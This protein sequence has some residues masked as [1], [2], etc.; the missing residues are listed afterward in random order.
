[1]L[2]K[3]ILMPLMALVL[4]SGTAGA[5]TVD[6]SMLS[7]MTPE[8]RQ[9]VLTGLKGG[10]DLKEDETS[11]GGEAV[12]AEARDRE[13]MISDEKC[14]D[15]EG[16]LLSENEVLENMGLPPRDL[17]ESPALEPDARASERQYEKAQLS[18][19]ERAQLA[20]CASV[21]REARQN[22][23]DEKNA[24]SKLLPVP[25]PFGYDLFEKSS[26]S[27]APVTDIP[28]PAD[29]V[30]G[31]GDSIRVQLTGKENDKFTLMVG[32]DGAINFPKLGPIEVA[33]LGFEDM[34]ALIEEQVATDLIGVGVSVSMGRLRSIRIFVLGDARHPGSYTVSSLSTLTHALYVSG[35]ARTTGSLRRIE[36]RRN[37]RLVRTLDL[38]DLLL[39]G[40]SSSDVRL[41]P[42]DVV[43]IPP[44]G[45]RVTVD[46]AVKRPAVYELLKPISVKQGLELAGG[47]LSSASLS[48]AQLER[49][50]PEQGRVLTA[51]NLDKD[52]ETK[53]RDGDFLRVRQVASVADNS[54]QVVG[55]IKYPGTYP[56]TKGITLGGVL[57]SAELKPSDR[58]EEAYLLMGAIERTD[59]VSGL[60]SFIAFDL[61]ALL[62]ND[63]GTIDLHPRD[64][65]L[66]FSRSDIAF[67]GDRL[68]RD[69]LLGIY[70]PRTCVGLKELR[71]ISNTQRAVRYL[72]A[73]NSDT[74]NAQKS[75]RRE[76]KCPAIF[77]EFPRALGFLLDR[78]VGLYGEVHRPG[79]YPVPEF[80]SVSSVLRGAGGLTREADSQQVEYAPL[81]S[82]GQGG[83]YQRLSLMD[84]ETAKIL[85][86]PGDVLNFK[87][88]LF[89]SDVG[90]VQVSGEVRFP[91]S[92]TISR[93]ETLS[94]L[95]TRAGGLTES[96]YPA[97]AIFIRESAK[98]SEQESFQRAA[99]DLQEAAVT[100]VTS[101]ALGKEGAANAQFLQSVV[102]RLSTLQPVGRIVI[103]ANPAA[104]ATSPAQDIRLEPGDQLTIPKI[105]RTVAVSGQVLNPGSIA[106]QEGSGYSQYL[107][108]AGG[109]SQ[110]ADEDRVFVVFPNGSA[111]KINTSWWSKPIEIPPGSQ[112]VV[113]R[114]AAPVNGM[115][116]TERIIDIFSKLALSAA[117]IAVIS[118]Q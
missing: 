1:M 16:Y 70:K 114:D 53:L 10:T 102:Q 13:D 111:Q 33:G 28:V 76:E 34:Q 55:H 92:Y 109:V 82:L 51:L 30:I 56:W 96:A 6:E 67:L 20:R 71:L 81:E 17:E 24:L 23:P 60:R 105:P 61:Q 58:Q 75:E 103:E 3:T 63:P 84:A 87:P 112:I 45:A 64:L 14:L 4:L 113:P 78:A 25:R 73:L 110:A 48:T 18:R 42:G 90:I 11:L 7:Q 68:V 31:P 44:V 88:R 8:Q 38:Y 89:D 77:A 54:V 32:R 97:G 47:L 72:R 36:L 43:F 118:N 65:V 12:S 41:E 80:S 101:G 21:R 86:E 2:S 35:G 98:K 116:L 52:L 29:F 37:G 93:G 94:Q 27:F 107:N 85:V 106:F 104:L 22:N 59:P 15:A 83:K 74:G 40:N 69:A 66:I 39:R 100:A 50:D 115:V 19:Y 49:A 57:R 46:G 95:L 9:K 117:S 91:G 5:A 99:T 62:A 26:A 79:V 108:L